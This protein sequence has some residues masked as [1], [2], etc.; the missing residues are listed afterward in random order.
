MNLGLFLLKKLG[1]FYLWS[2]KELLCGHGLQI[3]AIVAELNLRDQGTKEFPHYRCA[4]RS[5]QGNNTTLTDTNLH[6]F[7]FPLTILLFLFLIA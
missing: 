1:K 3:R 6:F 7:P 4:Y 2:L 5:G